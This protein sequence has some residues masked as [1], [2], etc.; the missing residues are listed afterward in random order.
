[1]QGKSA[2][3]VAVFGQVMDLSVGGFRLRADVPLHLGEVLFAAFRLPGID[4]PLYVSAKLVRVGA[5]NQLGREYGFCFGDVRAQDR[6]HIE[7]FVG[8]RRGLVV[9]PELEA[10]AR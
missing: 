5:V 9:L 10:A 4:A 6:E 8:A 3:G 1:M 2:D 7:Q